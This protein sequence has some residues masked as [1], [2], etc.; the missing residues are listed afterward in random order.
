M[1]GKKMP[2]FM[3]S[4]AYLGHKINAEGLHPLSD[5]VEAIQDAPGTSKCTRI[6]SLFRLTY[7]LQ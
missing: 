3:S 2:I 1:P 5:K 7:I 4:V 6:E